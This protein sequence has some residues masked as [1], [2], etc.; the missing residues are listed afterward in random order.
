M[1]ARVVFLAVLVLALFPVAAMA[2]Y[3][4]VIQP[5][6]TLTSVAAV[7]GLSIEA[8][9]AANGISPESQLVAGQTLWI[10]PRTASNSVLGTGAASNGAAQQQAA[11]GTSGSSQVT[12]TVNSVTTRAT[13]GS[14]DPDHDGDLDARTATVT[15]TQSS[16]TSQASTAAQAS[17]ATS[18]GPMTPVTGGPIPTAER[19]SSAEIDAVANA[20]GVPP[21]LAEAVAWQES[22]WNNAV[23]SNVGAVGVM[24]IVPSTWLWIDRYLTPSNPLGTA[25]AAENVRA[26]VLLLHQLLQ[27]T[28]GDEQLAVAG[29][30]QGLDSVRRH[31]MYASTRQYVADVLAL[32]QR[33]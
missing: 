25:S 10:P 29:Y 8:I 9:A 13:T 3:P 30:F 31:G 14:S 12:T 23:V 17:T 27:L 15:T 19:V 4:H 11:T 32:A 26:G 18:P 24:Q 1:R 33:L 6:E 7:D 28:G 5:G 20:Y 2:D 16:Q 22:G 21:A